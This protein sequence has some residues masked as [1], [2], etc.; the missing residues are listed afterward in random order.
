MVV[1]EQV[2]QRVGWFVRRQTDSGQMRRPG[3]A[4]S[5]GAGFGGGQVGPR[6]AED[7]ISGQAVVEEAESRRGSVT[8]TPGLRA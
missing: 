3:A 5:P 7:Q 6:P 1:V 4:R 8:S 2:A